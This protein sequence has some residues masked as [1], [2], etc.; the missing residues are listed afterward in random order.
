MDGRFSRGIMEK[1]IAIAAASG[2]EFALLA[3]MRR[4]ESAPT[5]L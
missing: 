3:Q 5:E 2:T 1:Q 4:T